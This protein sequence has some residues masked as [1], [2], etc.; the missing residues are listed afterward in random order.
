M[1]GGEEP[2][3][4]LPPPRSR[5]HWTAA[6][7]ETQHNFSSFSGPSGASLAIRP[8]ARRTKFEA[9]HSGSAANLEKIMD[10]Y[11]SHA[12]EQGRHWHI[13]PVRGTYGCV[14][15]VTKSSISGGF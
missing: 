9:D 6:K 1:L 2:D 5:R 14:S 13:H 3:V 7:A 15:R 4:N 11:K 10:S 12:C 8:Q